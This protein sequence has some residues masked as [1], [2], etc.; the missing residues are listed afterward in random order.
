MPKSMRPVVRLEDGEGRAEVEG[1]V[2]R[3]RV[4]EAGD[5]ARDEAHLLLLN[6]EAQAQAIQCMEQARVLEARVAALA[7]EAKIKDEALQGEGRAAAFKRRSAAVQR[8]I[9]ASERCCDTIK[10]RIAAGERCCDT[11][12]RR[13]AAGERLRNLPSSCG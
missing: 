1:G 12:K 7:A 6:T 13:F 2:Q 4:G 10:R 5:A 11:I 3:R 8:R 9:A